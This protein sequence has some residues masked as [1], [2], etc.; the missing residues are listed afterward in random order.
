MRHWLNEPQTIIEEGKGCY[1]K[2]AAGRWYLDGVS[3]LWANVHGHRKKEIDAAIKSQLKKI[4]HS[5]LLGLGNIP[6]AQLAEKLIEIAPRGLAKVFYSD[7]GSTAVEVALKIAFQYWQNKGRKKKRKFIT[8]ANA[9]HGDTLG[10]VSVGG[11]DLFHKIYKPLLFK[12]IKVRSPYC[13]RCADNKAYPSCKIYCIAELRLAL[14]ENSADVAALIVEPIVQAAAGIIVWPKGY[15]KA[16]AALCKKFNVLLIADEVA[17]GFGRTGKMFACQYENV[18]PDI[19]ALAKGITGGYL[20]LAAT[21]TTDEIYN[22]FLGDYAQKKTFFHGHTYTGNPLAAAAALANIALFEKEE[23]LKNLRPK[24]EFLRN[25]LSKF[26]ELAHVG[27]IRQKGTMVGIELVRNKKTKE[28]YGW[29]EKIG[30]RVITEA[31]KRG[32]ILR[33]LG[34]VLV[35]MPPLSITRAELKTLLDVTQESIASASS[36]SISLQQKNYVTP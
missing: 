10:S 11:M 33:P 19:M 28:P 23:V 34:N 18:T 5:T 15:L 24:I 35:L 30:I 22:A 6:S 36:C 27:D 2:D 16:A 21:L 3:S 20:P 25:G 32:V 17:T 31:K 14:L 12:S 4:S 1:V 13:Y 9:Y 8:L 29:E 7:N 26:R